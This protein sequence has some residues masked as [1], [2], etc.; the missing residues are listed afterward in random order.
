MVSKQSIADLR[1]SAESYV[2]RL[3]REAGGVA[4]LDSNAS[5]AATDS[6][7]ASFATYAELRADR[8]AQ[9]QT[10][11]RVLHGT[12]LVSASFGTPSTAAV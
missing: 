6:T 10:V 5:Y 7:S 11:R 9:R 1:K 2:A 12:P 8:W 3:M 4:A